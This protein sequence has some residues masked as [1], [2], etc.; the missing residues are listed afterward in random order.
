VD[1]PF[2]ARCGAK[3]DVRVPAGDNRPRRVCPSCDTVHYENPRVVCGSVVFAA[4]GRILMC[5]R[6]IAPQKGLWTLPA[7]FMETG[8]TAEE[9][10]MREAHEEAEATIAIDA[11]L[12]VYSLPHI[13]QV[14]IMYRAHLVG[15]HFAPGPESL[16]V[17]LYT[18]DEIPHDAIAFPTVTWALEHARS[19]EGQVSFAPDRRTKG[20][21]L[22]L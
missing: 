17:A 18:W 1:L 22:K 11:L 9:G 14:Q 4:D 16:E 8:E 19:V 21:P 3:V 5:K 7:G 15:A 13:A 20:E 10:A 6:A 2:C 12:A